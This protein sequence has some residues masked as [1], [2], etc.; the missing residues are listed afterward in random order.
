[1]S[2]LEDT[3]FLKNLSDDIDEVLQEMCVHNELHTLSLSGIVLAR[4]ALMC[5]ASGD[6]K[7][8]I[9][10]IDHVKDTI[11]TTETLKAFH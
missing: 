4:L 7:D 3:N 9:R 11:E 1:M 8:F 5:Q 2:N 6:T 10:L